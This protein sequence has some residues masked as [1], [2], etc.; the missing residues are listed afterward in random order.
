MIH[1][2]GEAKLLAA[3]INRAILDCCG[4]SALFLNFGN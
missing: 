2:K 3:I 1:A 4:S